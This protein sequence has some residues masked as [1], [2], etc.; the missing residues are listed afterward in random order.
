MY[1]CNCSTYKKMVL[2]IFRSAICIAG[3]V[4]ENLWNTAIPRITRKWIQSQTSRYEIPRTRFLKYCRTKLVHITRSRWGF[5]ILR[6]TACGL[7]G[8][9]WKYDFSINPLNRNYVTVPI[10]VVKWHWT[11]NDGKCCFIT[12]HKCWIKDKKWRF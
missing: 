1:L 6:F 11:E 4:T 3:A 9:C 5:C 8:I 2:S 12:L 7:H 10:D